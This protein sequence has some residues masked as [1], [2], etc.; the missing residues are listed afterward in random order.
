MRRWHDWTAEIL[1]ERCA[2][3][4]A[5]ELTA[6]VIFN[7]ESG[8]RDASGRRRREV[9]LD[10]AAALA[11]VLGVKFDALLTPR[12]EWKTQPRKLR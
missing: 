9:T 5:P 11:R 2:A 10:E 1:A 4:G 7:I 8:R 6:Q 12:D 3:A